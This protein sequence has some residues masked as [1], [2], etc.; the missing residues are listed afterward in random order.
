MDVYARMRWTVFED[1]AALDGADILETS[2]RFVEWVDSGPGGKELVGSV[3]TPTFEMAG[4]A[5]HR[6]FLH[7]DEESLESVVDDGRAKE[8][9]KSFCTMVR[10]DVIVSWQLERDRE[11]KGVYYVEGRELEE[12]EMCEMRKRVRADFLVGFYAE[13]EVN[14]DLWDCLL[15]S[16]DRDI[17]DP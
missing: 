4:T 7:V 2:R 16:E 8:W 15:W 10:P 3:Y 6:F 14:S 11:K 17:F 13:L 12:D 5:R 9:G 1:A